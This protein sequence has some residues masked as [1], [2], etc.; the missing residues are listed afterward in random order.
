M[1]SRAGDLHVSKCPL[2]HLHAFHWLDDMC[3]TIN[4]MVQNHLD[5][6]SKCLL[7]SHQIIASDFLHVQYLDDVMGLC[8]SAQEESIAL[9]DLPFLHPLW[10]V[11]CEDF[12][13][14]PWLVCAM[15]SIMSSRSMGNYFASNLDPDTSAS[16]SLRVAFQSSILL[17]FVRRMLFLVL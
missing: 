1:Y 3:N 13:L 9:S 5:W 4:N 2:S 16:G 15:S 17:E 11:S 8:S 10:Y 12:T 7:S 14:F 6:L